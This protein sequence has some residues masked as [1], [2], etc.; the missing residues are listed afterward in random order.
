MKDFF[1]EYKWWLIIVFVV[2]LVVS[3]SWFTYS[4][5]IPLGNIDK[6]SWLSFWGGFLAFYGTFFLGMVAIWQN[7]Q[8]DKQNKRLL[9]I[10]ES[11]YN[12]RHSCNVVLKNCTDD[13]KF[14]RLSNEKSNYKDTKRDVRLIIINHGDAML[15]K[16]KIPFRDNQEFSSHIVLA[17]GESKNIITEIP[18]ELNCQERIEVFFT[19]CNDI[20]TYGDFKISFIGDDQAEMKYYH[21]YGLQGKESKK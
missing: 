9:D 17:K 7:K 1:K 14:I 11:R 16:I 12:N 15:K 6:G 18:R 13:V 4:G 19:S 8:A 5:F 10:E 21:F 20:V 2:P 3:Y